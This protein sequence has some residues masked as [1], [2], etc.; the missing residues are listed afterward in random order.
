MARKFTVLL[1]LWAFV[2][3]MPL[4]ASGVA[5][6]P[7]ETCEAVCSH[8]AACPQDPCSVKVSQNDTTNT[9]SSHLHGDAVP[10]LHVWLPPVALAFSS[11]E[12]ALSN[13]ALFPRHEHPYPMGVFPLLI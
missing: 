1:V 12:K 8:E 6:H 2:L 5:T 11:Q 10:L 4:C 3:S 9:L 7:C 13:A